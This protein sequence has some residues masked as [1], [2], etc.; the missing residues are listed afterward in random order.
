MPRFNKLPSGFPNGEALIIDN[1]VKEAFIA[2]VLWEKIIRHVR[3]NPEEEKRII[4]SD[5]WFI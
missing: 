4:R 5:I 1:F 3:N 2:K